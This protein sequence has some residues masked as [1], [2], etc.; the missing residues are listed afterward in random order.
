VD[1]FDAYHMEY[2]VLLDHIVHLK[3][4]NIGVKGSGWEAL[5]VLHNKAMEDRVGQ[6]YSRSGPV[7]SDKWSDLT[8]LQKVGMPSGAAAEDSAAR[9]AQADIIRLVEHVVYK[10]ESSHQIPAARRPC[11]FVVGKCWTKPPPTQ[12]HTHAFA[13]THK[14]THSRTRS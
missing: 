11:K 2:Y 4:D 10:L 9:K 6:A 13:H 1:D 8:K 12:T 7:L 3:P 5:A 14:H